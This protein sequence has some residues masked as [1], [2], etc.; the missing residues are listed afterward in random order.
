M[1]I[2]LALPVCAML[3]LRLASL[4]LSGEC[5]AS[6]SSCTPQNDAARA[7]VN[8]VVYHVENVASLFTSNDITCRQ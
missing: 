7:C 3:S 8:T 6:P 4:R 2:P 1:C 5:F